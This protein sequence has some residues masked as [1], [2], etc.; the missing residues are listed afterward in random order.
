[1]KWTLGM[2]REVYHFMAEQRKF[3]CKR[4]GMTLNDHKEAELP[5]LKQEIP[6]FKQIHSQVLQDADKRW[7]KAL[8][9]FFGSQCGERTWDERS[10]NRMQK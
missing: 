6:E 9:A 3:A 4:R 7:D 10:P 1:M 2:C 5:K 8:Q